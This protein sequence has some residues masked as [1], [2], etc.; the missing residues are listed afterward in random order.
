MHQHSSLSHAY[1]HGFG[2]LKL[3]TIKSH[4]VIVH[5]IL[6]LERDVC[7]VLDHYSKVPHS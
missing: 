7:L 3:E 6:E 4:S 1:D 2:Q 5:M